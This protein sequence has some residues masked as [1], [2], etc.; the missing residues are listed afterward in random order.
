MRRLI[1]RTNFEADFSWLLGHGHS[2][3]CGLELAGSRIN[4]N[5]RHPLAGYTTPV[6]AWMVPV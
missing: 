4:L 2:A 3:D 5:R 1:A 6:F